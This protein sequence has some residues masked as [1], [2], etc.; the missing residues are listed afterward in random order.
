MVRSPCPT[1]PSAALALQIPSA[2]L[3]R[4]CLGGLRLGLDLPCCR[5]SETFCALAGRNRHG[6]ECADRAHTERDVPVVAVEV[7]RRRPSR[8]AERD[9]ARQGPPSHPPGPPG[10]DL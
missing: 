4:T 7:R 1:V 5:I 8:R 3:S 10:T 9:H 2:K 6:D